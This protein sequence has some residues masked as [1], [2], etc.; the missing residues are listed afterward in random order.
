MGVVA[1]L[2]FL[3]STSTWAAAPP[4]P[5]Y[6]SLRDALVETT[7][8]VENLVLHRDAGTITLK[9]GRLGLTARTLERDTV[10]VFEGEGE[11]ALSPVQP[12]ERAYLKGLTQGESVKETFDRAM[13]VFT[14]DTGKEIRSQLKA[15]SAANPKLNDILHDYR[16]HLRN[17]DLEN[18]PAELLTD[19]YQPGFKGFFSSYFHGRQHGD[20]RFHV[21]P[22]GASMSLGPEEVM[23]TNVQPA[24]VPDEVWYFSHLASELSSGLSNSGEDHRRVRATSYKIETTIA[25]NDHFTATTELAYDALATGDRVLHL[26]LVPSLRVS[27]VVSDSKEVPFIQE[28]R[29]LDGAF[30]VVL[31]NPLKAGSEHHLVITYEGDKVVHKAGGGNFSV[32]SRQSWYPNLNSFHDYARYDLTFRVPK[33]YTLV[34]VGKL[35]K[36]WQEEGQTCTHWQSETPLVVAGF[37]YGIFKRKETTD[38]T[39]GFAIEG[40]AN[41][42]MPDY[43]KEVA[44]QSESAGLESMGGAAGAPSLGSMSPSSLMNGTLTEAQNAIRIY[45]AWFGKPTYNRLALTQQPDFGFGQSW[46]TLVYLPMSAYLDSTQRW[47]LVGIDKGLSE[48]VEEVT[49]HEVAHQWWGHTVSDATYHDACK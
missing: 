10:A 24:G 26:D 9:S 11:F 33:Q 21:R 43:L 6:K 45:S 7:F 23:L 8:T 47:M 2:P 25:K 46:P 20:L 13:F 34:S 31:E 39:T 35:E 41:S 40:Y 15:A 14:D 30:Y 44:L 5:I 16:T 27:N 17:L 18:L 12:G 29:K 1:A 4:D 49:P 38:K 3:I 42:E 28:D 36:A 19:L 37:N 48:F 32:G 22:R